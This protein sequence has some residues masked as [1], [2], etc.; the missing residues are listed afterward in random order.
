MGEA[1]HVEH[2]AALRQ[3]RSNISTRIH[4]PREDVWMLSNR[5]GL[6]DQPSQHAGQG[7]GLLHSTTGRRWRQSLQMEGQI[8]LDGGAGLDGLDLQGGTDVGQHGWAKG[9][10]FGVVL[11]PALVFCPQVEGAGVLEVGRED[12]GL[13][14]GLAGELDTQVPRIECD[15]RE[16]EVLCR[17]V[18]RGKG[19][20]AVDGIAEGASIADV[21]P[22]QGGQAR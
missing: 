18:L 16:V 22:G 13:V 8:V 19:V 20:E 10:R 1:G 17:Q 15:E 2:L 3:E 4:G 7:H 5:L 12:D 21:F 14:A 11:L 9:Q 6:A